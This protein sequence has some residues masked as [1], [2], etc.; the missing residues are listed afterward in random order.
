MLWFSFNSVGNRVLLEEFFSVEENCPREFEFYAVVTMCLAQ[1]KRGAKE[2]EREKKNIKQREPYGNVAVVWNVLRDLRNLGIARKDGRKHRAR[3]RI[4]VYVRP[5]LV[6]EYR[7]VV[8]ALWN[9]FLRYDF[10]I[11]LSFCLCSRL[12]PVVLNRTLGATSWASFST[13]FKIRLISR[14]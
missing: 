10:R 12:G 9:A 3:D 2:I 7:S 14:D 5:K 4:T 6:D 11:Q 8:R 13:G 1:E